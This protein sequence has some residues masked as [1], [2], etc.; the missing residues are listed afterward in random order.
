[1]ANT[2]CEATPR[3]TKQVGR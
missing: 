3:Y 2:F 1:V